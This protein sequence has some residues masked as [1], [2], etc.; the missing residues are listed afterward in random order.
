MCLH[1]VHVATIRQVR[2][3]GPEDA[4]RRVEELRVQTAPAM[5]RG[6]LQE[7]HR[8]GAEAASLRVG[9]DLRLALNCFGGGL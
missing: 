2:S 7:V 1:L 6:A 8:H 5:L 3:L 9:L 4:S